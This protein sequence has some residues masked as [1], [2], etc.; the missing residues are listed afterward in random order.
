MTKLQTGQFRHGMYGFPVTV[1]IAPDPADSVI[2]IADA[3]AIELSL[4]RVWPKED[5][6]VTR[7]LPLNAITNPG[8]AEVHA[9]IE[10][11]VLG[12]DIPKRGTYHLTLTIDLGPTKRL[13]VEGAVTV[14]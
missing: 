12:G 4:R 6:G 14:T 10:F 7:S 8:S 9:V 1:E 3:T 11:T 2:S 5:E 13:I